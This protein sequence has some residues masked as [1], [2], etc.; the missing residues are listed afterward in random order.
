LTLLLPLPSSPHL[1]P[2]HPVPDRLTSSCQDGADLHHDQA[3]RRAEGP[4]NQPALLFFFFFLFFSVKIFGISFFSLC[5]DASLAVRFDVV[6][7]VGS[8]DWEFLMQIGDIISRFEKKGFYL[9]GEAALKL[10]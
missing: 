1:A 6:C 2:S 9:K 10:G 5:L 4:G 8:Y 7:L 3:R